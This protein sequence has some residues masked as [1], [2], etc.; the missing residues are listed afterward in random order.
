MVKIATNQKKFANLIDWP[1][2]LSMLPILAGGLITMHSFV[3]ADLFF[4]KQIVWIG[5][6]LVIFFVLSLLDYRFLN[7]T[8]IIT[9]LFVFMSLVLFS[10]FLI[11]SMV[12]G[13]QSWFDFG[14]F[15][16]QPSDFA[17]IVLI[18]LLAKYFS[19]RHVEIA[20]VR[21]ILVS[22][23]YAFVIF[24]L[25][26]LQ[27]DFGSAIIIFLLWFGMVLVS[28]ISK[29]H[30]LAVFLILVAVF[31]ALWFF[32]FENYQK[33][34][35]ITFIYPYTDISGAGYNARQ[36]VIAIGSGGIV[37][38]GVGYGTQS[39]LRFLPEY[40]TD[41]MFAAFAEEWGFIGVII[42]FALYGVVVWRILLISARGAT[43]FETF[44]GLGLAIMFMSHIIIHV[45]MNMGL[46]PITGTTIPFMSYGGSHLMTEFIGLGILMGM[47][48]HS[49]AM[50]RDDMKKEFFG[51]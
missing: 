2:F 19:R 51:L 6:S 13:A 37:G 28:G 22:G 15:S 34:R 16:F 11:G 40:E 14:K 27:P 47:R 44:F 31:S 25:V 32:G 10:L 35:I 48:R 30:L 42:L 12:R 7:S 8:K 29:K 39:R 41:F 45:G 4:N 20:N 3:G 24:V 33:Q 17:K 36:S 5:I 18:A 50:H 21:H 49:R 46:L 9:I 26:F 1:M 38:K 23:F 43:N